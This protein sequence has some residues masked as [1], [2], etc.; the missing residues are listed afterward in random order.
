MCRCGAT[1]THRLTFEIASNVG[2]ATKHERGCARCA[3]RLAWTLLANGQPIVAAERLG[4][5]E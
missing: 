3:D 4:G 1:A 2:V 5:K